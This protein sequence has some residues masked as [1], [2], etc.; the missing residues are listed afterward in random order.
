MLKR[1]LGKKK[2]AMEIQK[3]PDPVSEF[4]QLDAFWQT[5]EVSAARFFI[6]DL[7]QRKFQ[8][9]APAFGHHWVSF[10]KGDDGACWPVTYVHASIYGPMILLGGAMTDREGLK[11]MKKEHR[12][13]IV[14]AGGCYYTALRHLF[15]NMADQCEAYMGLIADP[16]SLSVSCAAGFAPTGDEKLFAYF[17]RPTTPQRREELIR[18]ALAFGE[19]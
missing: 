4:P 14:D 1:L 19:F 11:Q 10:Y 6:N 12:E 16:R 2:S 15:V 8:S 3:P 18:A 17:H 5:T 7:F 13:A 9:D